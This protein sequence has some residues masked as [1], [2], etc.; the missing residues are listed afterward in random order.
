[1]GYQGHSGEGIRLMC[2]WIWD[3]AIGPVR[4]VHAWTNRPVWQQG[5]GR[6]EEAPP[7]PEGL[8]WDLWL[9][10][11]PVR[12]YNPAYHPF[13][14]RAWLDF[15]CGA[16]GDMACH[17]LDPAFWALKLKYPVSVEGCK[18][19]RVLKIWERYDDKETY[20]DASVVRFKFPAREGMPEVKVSWYD[21]GIMPERPDEL[22]LGR[23]MGDDDGGVIFIG[24][25][26]KMM[27]GCYGSNPR[28][29]PESKM[30][31]YKR[32]KKTLPRIKNG[33][34]GHEQNWI[35]ACKAG[36][37]SMA[38]GN[39]DYSGPFTETVVM[40]NLSLRVPN[41]V[42]QWDGQNMK[43]TNNDAANEFVNPPYRA[44]WTL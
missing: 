5:M 39:F 38:C 13:S 23:M 31:A 42:L 40:G 34:D 25:K 33:I 32:P 19:Y 36:D 8:D 44:G 2:E 41:Q 21:G 6:P 10:P 37:P 16:L 14:W 30:E 22:E 15:G 1:M 18:S 17:I 35:D 43:F 20:P 7:V 29:I 3:G 24:D 4:E 9:G 27:C 28:L 12:P 26:G 11:A